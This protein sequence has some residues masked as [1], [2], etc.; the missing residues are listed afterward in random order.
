MCEVSV[1][2]ITME[3]RG[4]PGVGD[5]GGEAPLPTRDNVS[6]HLGVMLAARPPTT[7]GRLDTNICIYL[8]RFLVA[9]CYLRERGSM[10]SKNGRKNALSF[11]ESRRDEDLR[12]G[13]LKVHCF[14]ACFYIPK[15]YIYV[16][17]M[18]CTQR[19]IER[20]MIGITK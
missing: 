5:C 11:V 7:Q 6:E 18:K 2:S 20:R 1:P 9:V 19:S 13:S 4:G 14:V 10:P 8:F 12:V 17:Y 15:A 3:F 16:G